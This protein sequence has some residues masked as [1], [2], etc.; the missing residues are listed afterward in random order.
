MM[1]CRSQSV[2]FP[3]CR[4][5]F[6]EAKTSFHVAFVSLS[7]TVIS[8]HWPASFALCARPCSVRRTAL[9][10]SSSAPVRAPYLPT[11]FSKPSRCRRCP[12]FI[13]PPKGLECFK[14]EKV[15]ATI[16][17]KSLRPPQ[18]LR[19]P[20]L[21][22]RQSSGL[23]SFR[24]AP[25]GAL[26]C[27]GSSRSCR[28]ELV[29]APILGVLGWCFYSTLCSLVFRQTFLSTVGSFTPL[30]LWPNRWSCVQSSVHTWAYFV[31]RTNPSI[32]VRSVTVVIF[33]RP[34]KGPFLLP[35]QVSSPCF[36]CGPYRLLVRSILGLQSSGEVCQQSGRCG[37]DVAL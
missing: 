7:W 27:E 4:S 36:A 35:S 34:P 26:S 17:P 21:S 30:W 6:H 2:R 32:S 8:D 15:G 13:V 29:L 23:E 25:R 28:L 31:T 20:R 14:G 3:V 16:G 11:A 18:V 33:Q 37:L 10:V 22:R 1:A 19:S 24:L 12:C 9:I 5:W